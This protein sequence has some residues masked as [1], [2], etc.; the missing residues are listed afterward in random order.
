MP[1]TR[2]YKKLNG[3]KFTV[4]KKFISETYLTCPE[5]CNKPYILFLAKKYHIEIDNSITNKTYY[6]W[7]FRS[8]SMENFILLM[9]YKYKQLLIRYLTQQSYVNDLKM[10]FNHNGPFLILKIDSL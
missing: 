3:F 2:S 9:M 10:V 6:T 4:V 1:I 5:K 7:I 8:V